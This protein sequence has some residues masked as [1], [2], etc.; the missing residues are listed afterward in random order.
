[1]NLPLGSL[2][3][4]IPGRA[5]R[6]HLLVGALW[7]NGVLLGAVG[8]SAQEEAAS[9]W[10]GTADTL[11]NGAIH[12]RNPPEG[13]WP[14]GTGWVL[15]E[16]LRIGAVDGEEYELFSN[17]VSILTDAS[18]RIYVL[19][20]GFAGA[21]AQ[22]IRVFDGDG[23]FV[24]T[25]GGRGEGPAEFRGA[26]GMT[27]GEDGNLVVVDVSNARYSRFDTAGVFLGSATRAST[28]SREPWE[29][30]T[31]DGGLILDNAGAFNASGRRIGV[32]VTA[33]P[34]TGTAV[35]TFSTP[36]SAIPEYT[37]GV[38]YA[39]RFRWGILPDRSMWSGTTQ[40]LR[41]VRTT[42]TG[43]TTM[44]VE[45]ETELPPLTSEEESARRRSLE[46]FQSIPGL[47]EAWSSGAL[48]A[49]LLL[50]DHRPAFADVFQDTGGYLWVT[51]DGDRE[52]PV[53][54]FQIFDP[55]G[56][57]LGQAIS[58]VP[59]VSR[60]VSIGQSFPIPLITGQYLYAV[61]R[62]EFDVP[63]VVRLRIEKD[64]G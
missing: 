32:V 22:E 27:W 39:P 60:F 19:D 1:M 64:G 36:K 16:D 51:P 54:T 24:R 48:N 52:D 20:A 49:D 17:V 42:L 58:D 55:E 35:D 63:Y 56:R 61:T 14:E 26:V 50:I 38:S 15:R 13:I 4:L 47:E 46:S 6:H 5:R 7:I 12:V 9:S 11:A 53:D 41:I 62:D 10:A 45:R 34:L 2:R 28:Y 25:I 30:V 3:C 23:A 40:A 21:S 8:S 29:G 37:L 31:V 59:V 18:G 57:Y 33:D 44:V 43:D